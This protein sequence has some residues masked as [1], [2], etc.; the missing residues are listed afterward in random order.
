M[1]SSF[2]LV[3]YSKVSH[4]AFF[5]SSLNVPRG[6]FFVMSQL[7]NCTSNDCAFNSQIIALTYIFFSELVDPG[8][9][10]LN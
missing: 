1:G 7:R 10:Y 9:G 5:V 8:L 3:S 2:S 6:A 4:A